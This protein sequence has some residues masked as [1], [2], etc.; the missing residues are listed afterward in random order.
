MPISINYDREKNVIHTRAEGEIKFHDIMNYFSS[1]SELDLKKGYCVLGDY[2]EASLELSTKDMDN[3]AML[4]NEMI[5]EDDKINIAVFSKQDLTFG[6]GR[7][8]EAFLDS[9][10]YKVM[11]FRTEAEAKAWLGI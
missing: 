11:I 1:V 2:D 7:I 6:L 8:Y 4:R 3:M 5:D 10:K 9:K